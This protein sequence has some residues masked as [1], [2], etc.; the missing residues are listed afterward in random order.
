MQDIVEFWSLTLTIPTLALS[1]WVIIVF[2]KESWNTALSLV[3]YG[4]RPSSAQMLVLGITVGFIG[5]FLDNSYWGLAWSA[6]FFGSDYRATLFQFGAW[7]NIPFRQAA[8]IAAGTLHLWSHIQSKPEHGRS[9]AIIWIATFAGG[10]ALA[11]QRW[12]S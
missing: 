8:G 1:S 3:R 7:A 10:A 4:V 2:G 9:F 6:D 11:V 12:L 5:A